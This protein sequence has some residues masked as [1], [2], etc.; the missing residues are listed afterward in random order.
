M[1]GNV[2]SGQVNN[3]DD[4]LKE[5]KTSEVNFEMI[6]REAEKLGCFVLLKNIHSLSSPE[7]KEL[8]M[9]NSNKS[10]EEIETGIVTSSIVDKKTSLDSK[11]ILELMHALSLE[12]QEGQTKQVFENKILEDIS[13][14]LEIEQEL[15]TKK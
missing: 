7:F 6:S 14:V 2:F 4:T 13:K 12:K 15:G 10:V 11:K 3:M 1:L 9:E 5:G 8:N